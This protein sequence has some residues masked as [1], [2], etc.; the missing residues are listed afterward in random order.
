ME[1]KISLQLKTEKVLAMKKP[2]IVLHSEDLKQL[3]E[4]IKE[5]V[6]GTETNES[7][8]YQGFPVKSNDCV[9]R[10]TVYIYDDS[11]SFIE[12]ADINFEGICTKMQRFAQGGKLHGEVGFSHSHDEGIVSTKITHP[13]NYQNHE[14]NK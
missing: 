11:L 9:E 12:N 1:N 7:F 13:F 3:L 8:F 10:N 6:S 5:R 14:P 4:L 2:T